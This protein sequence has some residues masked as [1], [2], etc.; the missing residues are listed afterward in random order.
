MYIKKL[1]P[2]I[3]LMRGEQSKEIKTTIETI[4]IVIFLFGKRLSKNHLYLIISNFFK[5]LLNIHILKKSSV[6]IK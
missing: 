5:A 4:T 6:T 3:F 2:E 1:M